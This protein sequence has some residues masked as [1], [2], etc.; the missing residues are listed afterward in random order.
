MTETEWTAKVCHYL[1]KHCGCMVKVEYAA[2]RY[3]PSGWPDRLIVHTLGMWWIE[4]KG[5]KTPVSTLQR[6]VM[7]D[8]WAR[9]PCGVFVA[10]KG[11][12]NRIE[13]FSGEL[14]GLWNRPEELLLALHEITM[15]T[16]AANAEQLEAMR[17]L[18][19]D[20]LIERIQK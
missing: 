10:R 1:Q 17:Q 3:Q 7:R 19:V 13:M 12:T 4:F 14:V 2:S 15:R 5:E 6:C 16:R 9:Q 18:A 11:A 8:I 20:A